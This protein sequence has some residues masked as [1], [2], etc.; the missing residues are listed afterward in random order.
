MP[1]WIWLNSSIDM[2]AALTG[3]T[4]A[5]GAVVGGGVGT[6][7]GAGVVG[8]GAGAVVGAE[9]VGAGAAVDAG[10]DAAAFAAG[11]SLLPPAAALTMATSATAVMARPMISFFF[12]LCCRGGFASGVEKE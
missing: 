9:V 11:L 10:T 3:I 6:V 12:G 2:H 4:G 1:L 5:G 7:V 8:A